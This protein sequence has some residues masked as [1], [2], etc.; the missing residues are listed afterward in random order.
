MNPVETPVLNVPQN[1]TNIVGQTRLKMGFSIMVLAVSCSL[2][3]PSI[4]GQI[5]YTFPTLAGI[6]GIPGYLEGS[7]GGIGFPL[8]A[9]PSGIVMNSAGNFYVSDSGNQLI[10]VVTP[11]G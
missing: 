5:S 3:L 8:F 4:Q 11:S 2:G 1:P 9:N 10:R 6:G 7:N